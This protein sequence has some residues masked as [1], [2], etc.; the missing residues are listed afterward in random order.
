MEHARL[1]PP[2]RRTVTIDVDE[3]LAATADM[4]GLDLASACQIGLVGE[5]RKARTIQ[6]WKDDHREAIEAANA[7]VEKHGLPLAKYRLF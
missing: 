2:P 3:E 4:L 1:T 6:E 7:W 5:V